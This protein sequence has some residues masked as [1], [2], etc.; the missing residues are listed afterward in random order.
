[1][2]LRR[3]EIDDQ[4][5]NGRRNTEYGSSDCNNGSAIYHQTLIRAS[6]FATGKIEYQ[7]V[8]VLKR[9]H[10]GSHQLTERDFHLDIVTAFSHRYRR[11]YRMRIAGSGIS[12]LLSYS[13]RRT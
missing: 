9:A 2:I 3:L 8:G 1:M 4:P 7:P 13:G 5:C 10:L 11:D 12:G 6:K